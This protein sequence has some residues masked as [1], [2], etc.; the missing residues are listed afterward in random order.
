MFIEKISAIMGAVP[1]QFEPVVFVM[2][3]LF[4]LWL[5]DGFMWLAKYLVTGGR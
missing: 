5:I 1:I 2:A 4:F 3:A